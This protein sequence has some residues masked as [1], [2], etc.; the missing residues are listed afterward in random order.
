MRI[1]TGEQFL[2]LASMAFSFFFAYKGSQGETTEVPFAG[3]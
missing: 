2:V 1:I 3:K